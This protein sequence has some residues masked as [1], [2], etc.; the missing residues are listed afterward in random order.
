MV[1]IAINLLPPEITRERVKNARFYKIQTLGIGL[2][3]TVV[4]LSSFA[5]ALGILQS[6]WV[7]QAESQ[8]NGAL[9]KVMVYK[10]KEATLMALKDRLKA[11]NQY[12]E[13]PSL[14]VSMFNLL[15]TLL[16]PSVVVNNLS[17]GKTGDISLSAVVQSSAL[18]DEMIADLTDKDKNQGKI[19]SVSIGSLN[20]SRDGVYRVDFKIKTKL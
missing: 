4:F 7:K 6:Q 15:Y 2:V 19:E 12:R 1:K 8:M 5:I 20:R 17:V 9:Q 16:P 10:D 18:L 3:L 14:Q 11:I 13:V